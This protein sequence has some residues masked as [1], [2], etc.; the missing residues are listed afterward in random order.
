MD[1]VADEH[2]KEKI[3]CSTRITPD[4]A[5]TANN[6][7]VVNANLEATRKM[8]KPQSN[9]EVG[10]DVMVMAKKNLGCKLCTH[11]DGQALQG[12]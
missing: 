11:L 7:D 5:A 3:S 10:D 6:H 12:G 2:T 4:E 1:D 9:V 8:D